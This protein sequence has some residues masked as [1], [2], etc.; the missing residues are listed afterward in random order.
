MGCDHCEAAGSLQSNWPLS[1][2][3]ERAVEEV[4]HASGLTMFERD[5][6]AL[7]VALH[8]ACKRGRSCVCQHGRYWEQ[9]PDDPTVPFYLDA[10]PADD[11]RRLK[12]E[13]HVGRKIGA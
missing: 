1:T 3:Q 8:Q 5:R 12:Y 4:L 2:A 9:D 11:P 7:V 10:L 13:A 6:A